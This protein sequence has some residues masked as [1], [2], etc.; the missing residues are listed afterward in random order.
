MRIRVVSADELSS[1]SLRANDYIK[2]YDEKIIRAFK[3]V[4]E[5]NKKKGIDGASPDEVTKRMYERGELS[6]LDTVIDVAGIMKD[7]RARG[8]L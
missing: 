4:A 1:R 8:L 3:D 7:L 2:D 5:E 6:K